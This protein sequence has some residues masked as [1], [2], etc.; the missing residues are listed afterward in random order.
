MGAALA[1]WLSTIPTKMMDDL[2]STST[3]PS[4]IEPGNRLS[5]RDQV[6]PNFDGDFFTSRDYMNALDVWL[7]SSI[8]R[9]LCQSCNV[10]KA[11]PLGLAT[12]SD[13]TKANPDMPF[14]VDNPETLFAS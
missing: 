6:Y 14:R 5:S 7:Y 11:H 3:C 12:I 13:L 1:L 9:E 8:E 2:F 4:S 10:H